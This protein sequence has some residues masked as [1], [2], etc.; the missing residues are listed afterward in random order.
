MSFTLTPRDVH[1]EARWRWEL[2]AGDRDLRAAFDVDLD[3]GSE[4]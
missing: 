4:Q 2:V 1:G 3:P